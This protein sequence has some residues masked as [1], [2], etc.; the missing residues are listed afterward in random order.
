MKIFHVTVPTSIKKITNDWKET[1]RADYGNSLEE[2]LTELKALK[3]ISKGSSLTEE[4]KVKIGSK[5]K[6]ICSEMGCGPV[7]R[8]I[9]MN[10]RIND[11]C[12]SYFFNV[13]PN[14]QDFG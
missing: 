9:L 3:F 6:Y 14:F 1:N 5:L 7:I 8:I 13:P 4:Y 10:N 11:Q 2:I 12:D